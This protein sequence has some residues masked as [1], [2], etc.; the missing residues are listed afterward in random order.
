LNILQLF[1][2]W[3]VAQDAKL[4]ALH[5]LLTE[6]HPQDKVLVFSQFADTV[7]YLEEQLQARGVDRLAGVTGDS[8]DPTV[9]IAHTQ[10]GSKTE[11]LAQE[12]VGWGKPVYTLAHPANEHLLVLGVEPLKR[13]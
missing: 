12:V 10:P 4:N 7:H 5:R 2:E 9:L 8:S 6:T 13:Y 1:G 3:D 11:Q